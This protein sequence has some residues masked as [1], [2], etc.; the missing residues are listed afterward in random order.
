M[1]NLSDDARYST[2]L[3][4]KKLKG[5]GARFGKLF[6]YIIDS[7]RSLAVGSKLDDERGILEEE[8]IF[9]ENGKE[10]ESRKKREAMIAASN[11]Q[12]N[13]QRQHLKTRKSSREKEVDEPEKE[14]SQKKES[15]ISDEKEAK[16]EGKKEAV[17]P[18]IKEGQQ[19]FESNVVKAEAITAQIEAKQTTPILSQDA[20]NPAQGIVD[21]AKAL[22]VSVL[23]T[24]V[25]DIRENKGQGQQI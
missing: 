11:I 16:V 9:D 25:A 8:I 14:V 12:Q 24:Q 7:A 22:L 6:G 18:I 5:Y 13:T 2:Q 3:E 10:R 23:P 20:P 19:I 17:S 1:Q 21:L 15:A 4:G